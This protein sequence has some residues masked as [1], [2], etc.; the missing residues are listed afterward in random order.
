MP[1]QWKASRCRQVDQ[2]GRTQSCTFG[3]LCTI[4]RI[5]QC[6]LATAVIQNGAGGNPEDRSWPQRHQV[7]NFWFLCSRPWCF[8]RSD[9]SHRSRKARQMGKKAQQCLLD[10]EWVQGST[11]RTYYLGCTQVPKTQDCRAIQP[12][13]S[14]LE[15]NLLPAAPSKRRSLLGST[16]RTSYRTWRLGIWASG[17]RAQCRHRS[18][19]DHYACAA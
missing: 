1:W 9:R 7:A 15:T 3:A 14:Y 13:R 8:W 18:L 19:T 5:C 12:R 6:I 11:D 17:S 10:W 2:L 4:I 16:G